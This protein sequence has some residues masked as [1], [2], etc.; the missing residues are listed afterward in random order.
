MIELN[1]RPEPLRRCSRCG[2]FKGVSFFHKNTHRCKECNTQHCREWRNKNKSRHRENNAKWN[3]NNRKRA[4]VHN[5]KWAENNKKR[6]RESRAMYEAKIMSTKQGR[7]GSNM[8]RAIRKS[9]Q[10][11]TKNGRHWETL[12]G[13]TSKQLMRYIEKHFV[14]G[15]SW[16]NR[17]LWHIDHIIPIS[18]FSFE[19]PDEPDFKKC[20]SL[21]NLR[22]LWAK[23]NLSKGAKLD[24]GKS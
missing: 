18:A 17:H 5:R 2:E 16:E 12:V 11:K 20:W 23:D 9:L 6:R 1:Q 19:N 24:W 8:A 14:P 4:S 13:Y 7:L 22:P 21:T 15:M 3:A 10:S